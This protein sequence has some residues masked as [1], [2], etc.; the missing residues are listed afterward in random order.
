MSCAR[1]ASRSLNVAGGV[2][3]LEL[4]RRV[5]GLGRRVQKRAE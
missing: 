5:L 2:R 4:G 3:V 1:E